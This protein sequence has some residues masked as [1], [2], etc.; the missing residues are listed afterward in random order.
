MVCHWVRFTYEGATGFGRL[1]AAREGSTDGAVV[2]PYAGSLFGPNTPTGEVL[3]LATVSLLTPCQPGKMIG[4]WNNFQARA[5]HEGWAKPAHPLYF[6]KTDNCFAAHREVIRQPRHDTGPVVFEGELCIVI[7]QT[8]HDI[9]VADA[10]HFIFGYTCINDVTARGILK[11]DPSF[12]Q[13]S[14][15]KSFDTFGPFGLAITGPKGPKVS[16]LLARDHCGK[17]GSDLRI[18]RAVTS[19]MQV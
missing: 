6:I 8:C 11:S 10:D 4:L 15:A 16:K 18:P 13:W 17:D 12:P 3:P 14:R 1:E 5:A 9:S 2:K 19:L 7:G